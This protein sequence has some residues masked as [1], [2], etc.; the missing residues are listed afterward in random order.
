MEAAC[1]PYMKMLSMWIYHGIITDPIKEVGKKLYD[2][3]INF[4]SQ[5]YF[6]Y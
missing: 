3:K 4:L 1:V 6:E 2:T 5:N